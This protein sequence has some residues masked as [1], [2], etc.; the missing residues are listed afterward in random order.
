ME[1]EWSLI[2]GD[3]KAYWQTTCGK[4]AWFSELTATQRTK[5]TVATA[6]I[7]WR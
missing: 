2:L 1:C 6:V 4:Q 5:I 3:P 7:S